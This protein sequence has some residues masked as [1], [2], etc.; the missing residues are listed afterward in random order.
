MC[1]GSGKTVARNAMEEV[2]D[3]VGEKGP[4]EEACDIVVPVHL[5]PPH[6]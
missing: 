2:R 5:N 4:G 3:N 6:D 1:E